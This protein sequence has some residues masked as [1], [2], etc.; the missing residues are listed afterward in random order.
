M[1]GTDPA[2]SPLDHDALL[3]IAKQAV[4]NA[5]QIKP[6]DVRVDDEGDIDFGTEHSSAAVFVSA[7]TEPSSLVFR[8]L[9]LQDVGETPQVYALLNEVNID[10]ILGQVYYM[11]GEIWLHYRLVVD[12]PHPATIESIL[13]YML[14]FADD[15]D[16]KLKS[17]LGGSRLIEKTEDEIEV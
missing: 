8:T 4:A 1:A 3:A 14:E 5:C 17:R 15:Y 13:N 16:D 12:R 11:D 6:E 7:K 9:L 2:P 10:L